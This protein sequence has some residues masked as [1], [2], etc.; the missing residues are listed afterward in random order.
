MLGGV[1]GNQVSATALHQPRRPKRAAALAVLK[2]AD[3]DEDGEEET[4]D[5]SSILGRFNP[6]DMEDENMLVERA[7]I[8]A[9]LKV[10]PEVLLRRAFKPPIDCGWCMPVEE[11][12]LGSQNK[13][14]R[15]LGMSNNRR[16]PSSFGG[17]RTIS[18]EE[19]QEIEEV[20]VPGYD[21]CVMW[22]PEEGQEGRAVTVAGFVG[23]FLRE[24]QREGVRFVFECVCGLRPYNGMGCILADDMGLGKTLQSITLLYTL[25][26]CKHETFKVR[27]AL[28]VTPTA[29]VKNWE[30]EIVKWCG[31]RVRAVAL[32]ES[33]RKKAIKSI[34][35]FVAGAYEV[36]IISYETFRIHSELFY[37]DESTVDLLICDEA[38]RLKNDATQTAQTLDK[39][40]CKRR[41]L[42]SGTPMQNDLEEFF[43]MVNFCNPG[44]LGSVSEFRKVYQN[45]V[46]IGREPDATEAQV[47]KSNERSAQLSEIVNH[48][49][50]RRTN[51]LLAKHLPPKLTQIV[52]VSMTTM[53]K[54]M[55]EK[56]ISLATSGKDEIKSGTGGTGATALNAINAL[57]K[58]CNHP[59]L[60]YQPPQRGGGGG[61]SNDK[62]QAA[63]VAGEGQIME[64][65]RS[66]FPDGFGS[67]GSGGGTRTSL[68]TRSAGDDAPAPPPHQIT[69]TMNCSNAEW[70]GKFLLLANMLSIMRK[71]TKD[72]IV[73]V[74]NYTQTLDVFSLL[75]KEQSYPFV[76]L[77][78]S[79]NSKKRQA[80]VD[81]LNDPT[82]DVF[83]FLLSSKA[84][85]C[86]L[87]LI[88]ANRLVLFDPDWNPATDKQAAA[89]VWRDGAKKRCYVYRFVAT[90]SIEEKIYQRQL[91]KEGLQ[92]LL[93]DDK[94]MDSMLSTA[95]LKE[96]FTYRHGLVSDT[97]DLYNCERCNAQKLERYRQVRWGL[98]DPVQA[99]RR[100]DPGVVD[101]SKPFLE[102]SAGKPAFSG[103]RRAT[104]APIQP[105][106]TAAP[107]A[108]P[109]PAEA[110]GNQ[111]IPQHDFTSKVPD[112]LQIETPDEGALNEWSHHMGAES[113]ND[114]VLRKAAGCLVSFVFGQ[115]MDGAGLE[116]M[117]FLKAQKLEEQARKGLEEA[118]SS[119]NVVAVVTTPTARK[120]QAISPVSDKEDD[121]DDSSSS[122]S[123][124]GE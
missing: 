25:L 55:Y 37:D 8:L 41:I 93:A 43:A 105:A 60:M 95:Q 76:R 31:N 15:S 21:P 3:D 6:M 19:M 56:V 50:L 92:G 84:G 80:L 94:D 107:A 47:K 91:S 108:A 7:P 61:S 87:N 38:H 4:D 5:N 81:R 78:G 68:R 23:R 82:D 9:C 10:P 45:P 74:S 39:L 113:C 89:R 75:C 96:L 51:T 48:F 26:R 20:K 11:M 27:Q 18:P 35:R 22:E 66:F 12:G 102:G 58:I 63:A 71:E 77:D 32:V 2:Y 86:G 33:D 97:H 124:E 111:V 101:M 52:C 42:L 83:V 46:L 100:G 40:K 65:L 16:P 103:P 99:F 72:R 62:K 85:G 118:S 98:G 112:C 59:Q 88:G 13:G 90:G 117:A 53:Q 44:V 116:R 1:S 36:C 104:I 122:S 54:E 106:S 79:T 114:Y 110:V 14:K 121:D 109:A 17:Y 29:L 30:N 67:G 64:Q 24:H 70:S 34:K 69:T 120:K 115:V 57:K 49:I 73:I 123:S 119:A 28:I